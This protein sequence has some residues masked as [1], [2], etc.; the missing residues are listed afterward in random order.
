MRKLVILFAAVLSA[1]AGYSQN[2]SEV[3]GAMAEKIGA[4]G[5]YRIDFE[6]EMPSATVTSIGYCLVDGERYVIAIEDMSQGSDGTLVWAVNTTNQEITL[7][8]PRPQSRS[9][10]DNPTKA[11]DFAEEL[12]VVE[13][14]E[15]QAQGVW[16]LSLLPQKG[17]LDG[18]ERVEV[19]VDSKS[20]LP[21][22]LG[23]DMAGVGL[24][25]KIRSLVPA[26]FSDKEFAVPSVEGFEVIDFR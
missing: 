12:F 8:E 3:L 24:V 9:L 18:I 7:D 2:G 19:W 11:F 4:M 13:S 20:N 10:F 5:T 17:V 1:M 22:R 25:V 21:I 23:Y 15:S 14:A 16:S 6:L 26:E